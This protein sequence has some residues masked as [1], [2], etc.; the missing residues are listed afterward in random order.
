MMFV[1]PLREVRRLVAVLHSEESPTQVGLGFAFGV[2]AGLVPWGANTLLWLVVAFLLNV[3]FRA[4]LLAFAIF[5]LLAWGLLPVSHAVGRLLLEPEALE[6]LWSG[7]SH[8][9][10]LAWLGLNRYAVVGSYALAL[11]AAALAFFGVRGF[12]RTYRESLFA[13]VER[14]RPGRVLSRR[15][16][17]F[18][19]LQWLLGGGIRFRTPRRRAWP[20]RYVRTTALIVVP[21]LYAAAYGVVALWAPLFVSEVVARG[22]ARVIGGEV[23]VEEAQASALTG[24]LTL[25]G[26]TVQ[27]P[28]RP[29]EDVLRIREIVADLSL[30]GLASRRVVLDEL[31]V[32]EVF[33]HVRREEDGSLNLDDLS[34]GPD[35]QPYFEWLREQAGRVDWVQLLR[36]YGE[37]IGKR[38]VKLFEPQPP[39][40]NASLLQDGKPL[41]A[42]GPT[43]VV[44]RLR[45]ERLHLRLVDEFRGL[46]HRQGRREFPPVTAVDVVVEN[47]AW[48]PERGRGP[49][50][51]GLTAYLD[52]PAA[53]REDPV[54]SGARVSLTAI[55]DEGARP[56][57][58]SYALQAQDVD[59][60]LW[61]ALFERSLPVRVT[62]GKLSLSARGVQE[63]ETLRGWAALVLRGVR[64]E[65]RDPGPVSGEIELPLLRAILEGLEA[66]AQVCPLLLRL[67]VEGTPGGR[68]VWRW[69]DSLRE[70]VQWGLLWRGGLLRNPLL[71][72]LYSELG[73]VLV[74]ADLD[75]DPRWAELLAEVDSA[76]MPEAEKEKEKEGA[77]ETVRCGDLPR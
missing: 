55:F 7:L 33:L 60:A 27:D 35:L 66:Y 21:L 36:K 11:P 6:P 30:W 47:F 62:A 52:T 19:L 18:R 17:L 14:S 31:V 73:R 42:P 10:G 8:A 13:R 12:V 15:E 65:P 64:W 43:F 44:K 25:Q 9:P 75:R 59:W 63:G 49:I 51:L 4:A 69:D 61:G 48:R 70:A 23:S 28:N 22:A 68:W 38:L 32:G 34:E 50:T 16:R 45:I 41:P 5:R 37:T 71:E 58:R 3:S 20:F 74:L 54:R 76:A 67:E 53:E 2:L 57:R 26:L 46:G 1:D 56:P 39:P 29:G 77:G 24:R 72:R 40:P